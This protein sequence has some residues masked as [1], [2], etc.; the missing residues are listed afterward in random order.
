[1]LNIA[2]VAYL[3]DLAPAGQRGRVSAEFNLVTGATTMVGSLT[4]ALVLGVI[5]TP[6]TLW[7]SLAY[8]YII[9]AVG[10]GAAAFLHLRLP[11]EKQRA[12]DVPPER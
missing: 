12:E 5:S 6:G 8:L 7:A 10:R 1:L 9:A 11:Y 2:F 4:S 3:Y